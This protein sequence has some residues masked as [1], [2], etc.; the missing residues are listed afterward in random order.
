MVG[1]GKPPSSPIDRGGE[2]SSAMNV[3]RF[4]GLVFCPWP[5][6][7]GASGSQCNRARALRMPGGS[8]AFRSHPFGWS[9]T[10]YIGSYPWRQGRELRDGEL[11][12]NMARWLSIVQ[13]SLHLCAGEHVSACVFVVVS[14]GPVFV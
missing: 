6:K 9:L 13:T 7:A 4:F 1:L 2:R 5:S 3:T 11:R 12:P 10:E 8:G 14:G